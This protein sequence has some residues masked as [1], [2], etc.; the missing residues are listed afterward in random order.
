[1]KQ[2]PIGEAD[3]KWI[4]QYNSEETEEKLIWLTKE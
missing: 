2:N 4:L 1:M 3:L